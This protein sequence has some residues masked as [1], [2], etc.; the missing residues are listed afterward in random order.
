MTI[1]DQV[2]ESHHDL[3]DAKGVTAFVTIDAKGRP[4]TTAVWYLVDDDGLLK[5]S[6][7]DARQKYRNV[8]ANPHVSFFFVDPANPYHTLEVRA[9]AELVPDPDKSFLRKVFEHYG[10]DP[11]AMVEADDQRY[12]VV[13]T[14]WRVVTN[15]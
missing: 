3:L 4:Q 5:T 10:A 2:P 11:T 12:Q 8:A 6:L 15:G 7:S 14:P 1:K 9:T 13:L